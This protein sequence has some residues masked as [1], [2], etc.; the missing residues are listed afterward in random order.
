[1]LEH[2]KADVGDDISYDQLYTS[3]P[4]LFIHIIKQWR[5]NDET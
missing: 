1:M 4:F 3:A 5:N 2:K